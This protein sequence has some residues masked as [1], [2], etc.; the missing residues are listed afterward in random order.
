MTLPALVQQNQKNVAVTRLKQ[1]YSQLYQAIN[2]T[3]A[4]YGD[5]KNWDVINNI[6]NSEI[7]GENPIKV[8]GDMISP[9]LKASNK[10]DMY[11]ISDLGY[12][13]YKTKDGRTYMKSSGTYYVVELANGV[14]L[15]MSFDVSGS[16]DDES[17]KYSYPGIFIDINGKTKPN[18]TGQDLFYFHF[19]SVNRMKLMP[20]CSSDTREQ[21]LAKC[22]ANSGQPAYYNL[23]CTALIM[24]DGWEIKKDYPW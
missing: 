19:D 21:L 12:P 16:A 5:M 14:T 15:F 17:R 13:G 6:Y 20:Y 24:R 8:F 3:Q 23:C 18:I 1:T 2:M 9:Y 10:P 11:K 7:K 4:E 22:A